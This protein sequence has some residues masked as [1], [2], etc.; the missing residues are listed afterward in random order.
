MCVCV[1]AYL[2]VCVYTNLSIIFC[3]YIFSCDYF[4]FSNLSGKET[5]HLQKGAVA[6]T[7]IVENLGGKNSDY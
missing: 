4:P 6:A 2:G 7:Q 5:D 1:Q 3:R